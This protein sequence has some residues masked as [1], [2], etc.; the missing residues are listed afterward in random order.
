MRRDARIYVA[1][2]TGL[3]GSALVRRLRARGHENLCLPASRVDLT[4]PAAA[5]R[6][7]RSAQP[8]YVFLAAAKVGGILANRDEPADFIRINLAI[9]SHVL[10]LAHEHGVKKLLFLGSS[11]IYPKLAPQ[12]MREEQNNPNQTG[13]VR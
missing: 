8:E 3:V 13:A 1:G 11:C 12:P 6:W 2:H 5:A 4:D 9:A 7:F 10:A